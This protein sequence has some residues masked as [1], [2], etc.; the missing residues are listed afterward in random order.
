MTIS[1]RQ[2]SRK[3]ICKID[4]ERKMTQENTNWCCA[5][6][7]YQQMKCVTRR[8][9]VACMK[10]HNMCV[11]VAVPLFYHTQFARFEVIKIPRLIW[12][13]GDIWT[14]SCNLVSTSIIYTNSTEQQKPSSLLQKTIPLILGTINYKKNQFF[15]KCFNFQVIRTILTT[16]ISIAEQQ[17]MAINLSNC[18]QILFILV[19]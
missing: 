3:S 12:L 15:K 19:W 8:P 6:R 2:K 4:L 16:F 5:T 1:L 10:M 11:P 17:L 9:S 13:R 18:L 7:D 14:I